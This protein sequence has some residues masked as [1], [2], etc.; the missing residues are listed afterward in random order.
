MKNIYKFLAGVIVGVII[1]FFT[2]SILLLITSIVIYSILENFY[3]KYY[4]NK[5]S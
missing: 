4:L 2:Q 3:N 5:N 1:Y